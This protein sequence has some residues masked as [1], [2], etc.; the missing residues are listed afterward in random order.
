MFWFLIAK[1]HGFQF[2]CQIF[3][4]VV[5]LVFT[6]L[7]SKNNVQV[8][9]Q[10]NRIRFFI[11]SLVRPKVLGFNRMTIILLLMDIFAGNM[12]P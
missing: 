7:F 9:Y 8:R 11:L 4:I 12:Y 6:S 3:E 2:K 10:H 1:L 5:I